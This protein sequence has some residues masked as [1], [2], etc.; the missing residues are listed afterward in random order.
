MRIKLA[1][2]GKKKIIDLKILLIGDPSVGK[3]TLLLKYLQGEFIVNLDETWRGVN[4]FR[5]VISNDISNSESIN[6]VINIWDVAGNEGYIDFF[7]LITQPMNAII[8][9]TSSEFSEG[10]IQYSVKRWNDLFTNM[11]DASFLKF[12]VINKKP[13]HP[14]DEKSI[15][16]LLKEFQISKHF[17]IDIKN[18]DEVN[19][20]FESIFRD[21]IEI[22][23]YN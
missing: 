5:K 14:F 7:H 17:V 23:N 11:I 6:Y 4:L 12:L 18:T 8:I 15:I 2:N 20:M 3:T 10:N 1:V 22:F 9:L 19:S 16:N 21:V 13:N